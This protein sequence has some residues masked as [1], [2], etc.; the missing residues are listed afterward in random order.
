M[1]FIFRS[2]KFEARDASVTELVK[3]TPLTFNFRT[4]GSF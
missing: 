3:A 1:L 2:K 4:Y